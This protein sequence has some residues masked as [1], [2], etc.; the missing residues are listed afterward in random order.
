ML[1]KCTEFQ[2][3]MQRNVRKYY[4]FGINFVLADWPV[5]RQR[6]I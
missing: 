6:N 1:L 3:D 5:A 2:E 4:A